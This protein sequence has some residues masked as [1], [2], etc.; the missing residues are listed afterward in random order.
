LRFVPRDQVEARARRRVMAPDEDYNHFRAARVVK[1]LHD[2]GVSIQLGAHGQREGLAAHWEMW[3]FEQGG[4]TPHQALRAG[5][6]AGARYLG[7][8]Q[9]LGSL[10]P[11]KLADILVLER[12]PLQNLRDSESVLYTMVGGRLFDA[13]TMAEVHPEVG[14]APRFWFTEQE[15]EGQ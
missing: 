7:L 2:A 11:G 12:D 4:M 10:E 5:T 3:M 1:D 9:D 6:I 13:R 14:E 8:D 15:R